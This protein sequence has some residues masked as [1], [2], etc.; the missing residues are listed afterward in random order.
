MRTLALVLIFLL[1]IPVVSGLEDT[2]RC[3]NSTHLEIIM[4]WSETGTDR[5]IT[6]IKNCTKPMDSTERCDETYHQCKYERTSESGSGNVVVFGAITF[7]TGMFFFLGLR[8][9]PTKEFSLLKNGMQ[10][11]FFIIGFFLLLLDIGI[12]ETIAVSS[13]ISENTFN[14]MT[15]AI[16]VLSRVIYVVIFLL[17]LSFLVSTVLLLPKIVSRKK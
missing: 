12:A 14:L 10:M 4:E 16:Q 11:A 9:Q 15:T 7:L 17:V 13:G 6:Q 5:N 8:V 1:F 2:K 3:L